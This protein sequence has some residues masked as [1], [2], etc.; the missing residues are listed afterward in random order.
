MGAGWKD[1]PERESLQA[2]L[3]TTAEENPEKPPAQIT[4]V[5]RED[6]TRSRGAEAEERRHRRVD[7]RHEEEADAV[8]AINEDTSRRESSSQAISAVAAPCPS[9]QEAV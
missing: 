9:L 3:D 8:V 1:D 5:A 7:R 6:K 2:D 4:H